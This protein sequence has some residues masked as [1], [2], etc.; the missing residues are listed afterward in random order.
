MKNRLI[1]ISIL[2]FETVL[3]YVILNINIGCFFRNIF[4]ICCP[5]CGLTRAFLSIFNFD[6]IGAFKYNILSIPLFIFLV[7]V[8]ILIVYDIILNKNKV[9]NFI[10]RLLSKYYILILVLLLITT[11]IN[12]VNKI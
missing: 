8:N 12:N 11:I 10:N 1:K 2:I 7:I 9:W 4:G 3:L 6:L 5:G